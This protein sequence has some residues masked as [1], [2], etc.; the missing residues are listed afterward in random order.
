MTRI[1][2]GGLIQAKFNEQVDS[3][4][5]KIKKA[6][7]DKHIAL[8]EEAA[9]KGVQILCL[10]EMFYGPYFMAEQEMKWYA[11]AERIPDG[12]TT[13]LMQEL[14]RKYKMVII[15]PIMEECLTGVYYN[16]L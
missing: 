5:E 14:A 3:A 15:S 12:P 9:N 6:M 8:I 11:F 4:V 13:R 7:I 16:C 1:V 2:R 10:Q